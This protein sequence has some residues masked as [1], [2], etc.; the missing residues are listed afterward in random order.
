MDSKLNTLVKAA[1][2]AVAL[3]SGAAFAADAD[4]ALQ[5][6]KGVVLGDS[7]AQRDVSHFVSDDYV[8]A[9]PYAKYLIH[10]GQSPVAAR[11]AA[12]HIDHS[13]APVDIV[14]QPSLQGNPVE[15]HRRA[16]LNG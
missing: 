3:S 2:I 14:S 4:P 12:R 13:A 8:P 10:Q 15:L 9:G 7:S 16:V 1:A 5:T 11:A 6:Y